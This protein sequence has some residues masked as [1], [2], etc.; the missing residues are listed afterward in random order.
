MGKTWV[1]NFLRLVNDKTLNS[2]SPYMA[3][4]ILLICLIALDVVGVGR[5]MLPP[6]ENIYVLAIISLTS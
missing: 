6:Y 5:I 2:K 1:D 4:E 3:G